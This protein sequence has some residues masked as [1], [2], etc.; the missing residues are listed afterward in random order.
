M[1]EHLLF[2]EQLKYERERRGWSQADL[3]SKLG[4]DTKTVNRW[5]SEGKLPRPERRHKLCELVGICTIPHT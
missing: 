5:E 2:S 1:A 3:A 4:C